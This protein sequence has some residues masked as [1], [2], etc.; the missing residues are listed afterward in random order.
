MEIALAGLTQNQIDELL[1][2]VD[3]GR[4][5]IDA[6]LREL[7]FH[8]LGQRIRMWNALDNLRAEAGKSTVHRDWCTDANSCTGPDS[9]LPGR[10]PSAP[11]PPRC[12]FICHTGYFSGG[13]FGGATRASLAMIHEARRVCGHPAHGGGV[14]IIALVQTPVPEAL[15]FKLENDH[16]GELLWEGERVL[17]GRSKVLLSALRHRQYD[18]VVALSIEQVIL[19]F[20]LELRA[21]A[22][23]ATPHN[24]Y[25]PPF[26]PFRRFPVQNGHSAL[27]QKLDALLCPCRHHCEYLRRWGPPKIVARPLY[28]ADYHYFH[29]SAADGSRQLAPAMHP[30]E[31][32]HRFVTM[33][34]PSP[35]KGLAI[36]ITLARRLPAVAFAAVATQWTGTQTIARLKLLPN[37]TILE[38]N[39]NVDVIFRQTRVLLAPSLWQE[40]CPLIVMEACLR[41]IPCISS[42]VFG[43]P[44]A[45]FNPQLIA[46]AAL[47]YDHARGT[48]HHGVSNA[49]LEMRLGSNP[50]LPKDAERSAAIEAATRQE[51]TAEEAAPFEALLVPLLSDDSRLRHESTTCRNAFLEFAR[52]HDGGLRR[53]LTS[54]SARRPASVEQA[55]SWTS[56]VEA[57]FHVGFK[58][59]MVHQADIRQPRHPHSRSDEPSV[60]DGAVRTMA[61][62]AAAA[63]DIHTKALPGRA[64]YCVVHSPFVFLRAAPATDAAVHNILQ[65]GAT[66]EVDAMRYGWVRTASPCSQITG[67]A[68]KQAWALIDGASLGLGL[69]LERVREV[70]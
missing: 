48:L 29:E 31:A 34:S 7:G 53:E 17:V 15:V 52:A 1:V 25:L 50:A 36:F 62:D 16:L 54:V 3:A 39:S 13:S 38:A 60:H 45:N 68:P 65:V 49:Q 21:T 51:A 61:E 40:C 63:V 42:D 64:T 10:H 56:H 19:A 20:A 14:D 55:S 2:H 30:W 47:S 8:K 5:A 69:L 23:Y 35:E 12:A 27:L 6:R 4:S 43:L 46:H 67:G 44:E 28:A 70:V 66:L 33:V 26:G 9:T 41:G 24:Y 58:L 59:Q 57:A 11:V 18:I 32:S 22:Y 37:V